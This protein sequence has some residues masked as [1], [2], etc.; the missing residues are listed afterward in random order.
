[1]NNLN[2]K[3]EII[4]EPEKDDFNY[5]K[6]NIKNQDNYNIEKAI[7]SFMKI[8]W[9]YIKEEYKNEDIDINIY[10]EKDT[11]FYIIYE[12]LPIKIDDELFEFFDENFE[13]KIKNKQE[14]EIKVELI[15]GDKSLF[16]KNKINQYY[17]IFNGISIDKVDFYYILKA[18]KNIAI[19]LLLDE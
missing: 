8:F 3:N 17:L 19:K 15:E 10:V 16:E 9:I 13:R 6:I 7:A 12:I 4:F 11:L 1:M 2:I 18:L 5:L 14:F